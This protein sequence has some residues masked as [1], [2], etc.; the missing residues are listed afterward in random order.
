MGAVQSARRLTFHPLVHAGQL[1][2]HGAFARR[3]SACC[4]GRLKRLGYQLPGRSDALH[5]GDQVR[6]SFSFLPLAAV[7]LAQSTNTRLHH[8]RSFQIDRQSQP[9]LHRGQ[10]RA[11]Q[12][13][14]AAVLAR[15]LPAPRRAGA[16]QPAMGADAPR[17]DNRRASRCQ[18]VNSAGRAAWVGWRRVDEV[19]EGDGRGGAGGSGADS[20]ADALEW[21]SAYQGQAF[22]LLQI[23]SSSSDISMS[24]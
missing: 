8:Q 3:T 18:A 19:R 13:R 15:L 1:S 11:R 20:S 9:G 14:D 4:R 12:I 10:D 21:Q 17:R 7:T 6:L 23:M 16:S 24:S 22:F 5:A 2:I